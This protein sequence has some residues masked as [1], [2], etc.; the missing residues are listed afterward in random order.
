MLVYSDV[1]HVPNR[2]LSDLLQHD[3]VRF[4]F[5]IDA[6][7]RYTGYGVSACDYLVVGENFLDDDKT[8][9]LFDCV[10][11]L[12]L[13][14]EISSTMSQLSQAFGCPRFEVWVL[15]DRLENMHKYYRM[16]V[17]AC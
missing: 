10:E 14:V 7:M 15:D 8:V 17:G 2:L 5:D 16:A 3:F 11:N 6:M 9:Y 1:V 4:N 12:P 13:A